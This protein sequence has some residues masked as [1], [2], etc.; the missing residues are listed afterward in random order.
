MI[1]Q[2]G[3]TTEAKEISISYFMACGR[4]CDQVMNELFIL[5]TG[6]LAEEFFALAAHAGTSVAAFVENL[7]K[8]KVGTFL[9]DRPVIWYEEVSPGAP[10]I[11]ALSTTKRQFFIN[12]L[13]GKANFVNVVHPSSVILPKT[14]IGAGTVISTGVLIASNTVIGRHV[15]FNRGA[16]VGHHTKVGD[17]VTIQPGA[18]IAGLVEIGEATYIGMGAIII[19]R[20]K[21]G[22]GVTVAAGSVITKDIPD[23]VLVAGNPAQV[24][25]KG[26][27]AR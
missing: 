3:E 26:I 13:E 24:K 19:E 2:R 18:N 20:L 8:R 14:T 10:C 11:C 27:D 4:V 1:Q 23:H 21:I 7:D 12:Q 16:R 9:C 15:F 25:K 22:K 5:G 6:V 17:F